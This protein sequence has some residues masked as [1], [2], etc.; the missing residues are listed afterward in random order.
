MRLR[1]LPIC[2]R[3]ED[4]FQAT[5]DSCPS[6]GDFHFDKE[7]RHLNV[8]SK[9]IDVTRDVEDILCEINPVLVAQDV[10]TI[11]S[12]W[13]G[14]AKKH[15]SD[16]C[17]GNFNANF[18]YTLVT[19][20]RTAAAKPDYETEGMEITA[21]FFLWAY[22]HLST[23]EK[24]GFLRQ[25][26]LDEARNDSTSWG[27]Q[28]SQIYSFQAREVCRLRNFFVRETAGWVLHR[29]HPLGNQLT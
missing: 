13:Y 23:F 10:D 1:P 11:F 14:L 20:S 2:N 22:R 12:D 28:E 29:S 27:R 24:P 17:G 6:N 18:A 19:G 21:F 7:E 8:K 9:M 26:I 4:S 5:A 25:E 3:A 16:T 15:C